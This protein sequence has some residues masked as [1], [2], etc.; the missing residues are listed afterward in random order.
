MKY[1]KLRE[2]FVAG[3]VFVVVTKLQLILHTTSKSLKFYLGDNLTVNKKNWSGA[4]SAPFPTVKKDGE[5]IGFEILEDDGEFKILLSSGE[6]I[7]ISCHFLDDKKSSPAEELV[8]ST[9]TLSEEDMKWLSTHHKAATLAFECGHTLKMFAHYKEN[10]LRGIRIAEAEIFGRKENQ[11]EIVRCN[12]K[13][14]PLK[15]L[16]GDINLYRFKNTIEITVFSGTESVS[17]R[18]E[19]IAEEAEQSFPDYFSSSGVELKP[20]KQLGQQLKA[21]MKTRLEAQKRETAIPV[22]LKEGALTVAG[23]ILVEC[24]IASAT[25]EVSCES[26]VVK[27]LIQ[28]F[29]PSNLSCELS[30][31]FPSEPN[32]IHPETGKIMPSYLVVIY[33]TEGRNRFL[34]A[35][36]VKT[37]FF[38]EQNITDGNKEREAKKTKAVVEKIAEKSVQQLEAIAKVIEKT[39]NIPFTPDPT[40]TP[41]F[42]Q[43]K[44][45]EIRKFES[46]AIRPL[47]RGGSSDRVKKWVVQAHTKSGQMLEIVYDIENAVSSFMIYEDVLLGLPAE[48]DT[49]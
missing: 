41:A 26:K 33:G 29:M 17:Y 18:T 27:A 39:D 45:A 1:S 9:G 49:Y 38:Y 40:L 15:N 44:I 16:K 2:E 25:A 24:S 21:M 47:N 42:L 28:D 31:L 30:V 36:K 20:S 4:I 35:C 11:F 7:E 8:W 14:I 48:K 6:Q 19:I 3:E 43:G 5:I 23:D 13:D 46:E 34:V 37:P 10:G 32:D 22:K 12:P